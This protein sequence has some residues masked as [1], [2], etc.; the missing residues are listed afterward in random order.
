[1]NFARFLSARFPLAHVTHGILAFALALAALF[2]FPS[3][4]HPAAAANTPNSPA[5]PVPPVPLNPQRPA[6]EFI[7]SYG[8]EIRDFEQYNHYV[9]LNQGYTLRVLDIADPAH[10]AEIAWLHCDSEIDTMALKWPALYLGQGHSIMVI[11]VSDP[12]HFHLCANFKKDG[13]CNSLK[14]LD[15]CLLCETQNPKVLHYTVYEILNPMAPK[16]RYGESRNINY[17]PP[18]PPRFCASNGTRWFE[19]MRE[20][21]GDDVDDDNGIWSMVIKDVTTS[22][23]T[24]GRLKIPKNDDSDVEIN[25]VIRQGKLVAGDSAHTTITL[26]DSDPDATIWRFSHDDLSILQQGRRSHPVGAITIQKNKG[27]HYIRFIEDAGGPA[28]KFRGAY[29]EHSGARQFKISGKRGY[30][31]DGDGGLQILDLSNPAHPRL[32]GRYIGLG[33]DP[34]IRAVTDDL[35]Y[36]ETSGSSFQVLDCS[37]PAAPAIRGEYSKT[38]GPM[39]IPGNRAYIAAGK[40]G[41]Q[42]LDISKPSKIRSLGHYAT[43]QPAQDLATSGSLVYLLA[44]DLYVLDASNP[45]RPVL[46][47]KA[48][49]EFDDNEQSP[50]RESDPMMLKK[51]GPAL[52]VIR[53]SHTAYYNTSS[54]VVVDISSP[55]KPR[56]LEEKQLTVVAPY[57][58]DDSATPKHD[59]SSVS[60]TASPYSGCFLCLSS[61]YHRARSWDV[62]N[63]NYLEIYD[64]SNPLSPECVLSTNALNTDNRVA[65]Y[66]DTLYIA[67]GQGGLVILAPPGHLP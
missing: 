29:G 22:S 49:I 4:A 20:D 34:L 50:V 57:E 33:K 42:I 1:M 67:D 10:P 9:F 47:G 8:G 51:L 40:G 48:R 37:N 17:F 54:C 3:A 26:A 38:T 65:L 14:V 59:Q 66:K 45:A 63:N 6:L 35:L 12:A 27:E 52:Y 13:R 24:L 30:L 11:D 23:T 53:L 43:P 25:L 58:T 61:G 36:I 32:L 5:L 56:P 60:Q 55:S 21:S 2:L 46:L 44:G 18:K 41:L 16:V 7:G 28:P 64:I 39:S 31:I 62:I 15:N 19:A